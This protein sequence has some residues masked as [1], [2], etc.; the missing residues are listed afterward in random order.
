MKANTVVAIK[1]SMYSSK[2]FNVSTDNSI[3][4]GDFMKYI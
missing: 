1:A 3:F 4:E 2:L